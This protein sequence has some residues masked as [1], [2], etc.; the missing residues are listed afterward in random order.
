M[1]LKITNKCTMECTHCFENS[2]IDGEHMTNEVFK[3]AIKFLKQFNLS[4]LF[5]SGGE[6]TMH[7]KLFDIINIL[8]KQFNCK[9]ILLSNGIFLNNKKYLEQLIKTNIQVQITNDPRYYKKKIIKFKHKNFKYVDNIGNEIIPLGRAINHQYDIFDT[10]PKP[11]CYCFRHVFLKTQDMNLTNIYLSE[12]YN[13]YCSI[14]INNKGK[15]FISEC[16]QCK[17]IGGIYD[18]IE[19]FNIKIKNF[20]CNNCGLYYNIPI[21]YRNEIGEITTVEGDL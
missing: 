16:S 7:P 10:T 12:V 18:S 6:P 21:E 11:L 9:I 19:Y 5:I 2:S 14:S 1:I 3:Q 13:K 4:I 20:K 15:V 8:K 17:P